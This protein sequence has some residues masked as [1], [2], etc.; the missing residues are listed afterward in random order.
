MARNHAVK[1]WTLV[2]LLLAACS[3]GPSFTSNQNPAPVQ[4][5]SQGAYILNFEDMR[6]GTEMVFFERKGLSDDGW[7][8]RQAAVHPGELT[9]GGDLLTQIE[10]RHVAVPLEHTEVSGRVLGEIATFQV[11]QRFANPFEKPIE[12]TYVFPLPSD[13]AVTDFLMTIGDRTIRGFVRERKEAERL[14]EAAKRQGHTASLMTQERPNVF[15]Q[16]VAGIAPGKTID[17]SIE[18]LNRL[19]YQDGA[20]ELAFPMVVGPRYNPAGSSNGIGA[21]TRASVGAS[22]Q[23]V[24]VPYLRPEERS[25]HDLSF[26]V[27]LESA[28]PLEAIESPTHPISIERLPGGRTRVSLAEGSVLPNKDFVLRY[29]PGGEGVRTAAHYAQVGSEHYVTLSILPPPLLEDL[30]AEPVELV[31]VVD[32]SGSMDGAPMRRA[33]E[34]LHEILDR[35]TPDDRIRVI[36]FANGSSSLTKEPVAATRYGIESTREYVDRMKAGGGT[37][38]MSGIRAALGHE[39]AGDRR[40]MVVF[41]TDG[42]IGNEEEILAEIHRTLGSARLFSLGIGSSV[43]RYLIESMAAEGRGA[44]AVLTQNENVERTVGSLFERLRRPALTDLFIDWGDLEVAE[45]F[46]S[47]QSDLFC[48]RPLHM[49]ARLA[50][51]PKSSIPA[52][53]VTGEAG[54]IRTGVTADWRRLEG[55]GATLEKLWARTKIASLLRSARHHPEESEGFYRQVTQLA[56]EHGLMS[57]TTAF[58]AVDAT[59]R[60]DGE[61]VSVPVSVPMPAGVEFDT[62]VEEQSSSAPR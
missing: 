20:Y 2:G 4:D 15:T 32:T 62:T 5:A 60:A 6:A 40:K 56:L 14:Y 11:L 28:L 1:A 34:A 33:K 52:I 9:A 19:P 17:V 44:S 48:G 26:Q 46:P 51:A 49:V 42:Y 22:G 21:V 50:S 41:L 45:R 27:D 61:W 43:N 57:P 35:L 31:C 53:H 54:G 30:P 37:E 8:G 12:A 55:S 58:L 7:D 24:E 29:R 23:V 13:A 18:Y 16:K 10:D 38:M 59:Q 47:S 25:G 3:G 36:R 39:A